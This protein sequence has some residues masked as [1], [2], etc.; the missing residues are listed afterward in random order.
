MS[1]EIISV[2]LF[3]V[4]LSFVLYR[5]R[6]NIEFKTGLIIRR[7]SRGKA[8]IYK[9]AEKHEKKLRILGLIGILV[10]FLASL[11][12]TYLL[13]K[14]TYDVFTRKTTESPLRVVLPS[15]EG[16][17]MPGFVLG[18]PFWYW[19]ISVFVVMLIHEPMH[20][21]MARIE[22][23]DIKSFGLL[24]FL[25]IPG[26]FVEPNERQLKRKSLIG[27][28]RVF[29]AGS[30]GNIVAAGIIF[31]LILGFTKVTS[32]FI[33]PVGVGF[34]SLITGSYAESVELRG[35]ITELNGVKIK[36]LND[37]ALAMKDV[38]PGD[39]VVV[40]TDKG[41]YIIKTISDPDNGQR[42]LVGIQKV[43]VQYRYAPFISNRYVSKNLLSV[44]DWI[45]GL[46][47]WM[48]I[49]NL[50]VGV[51][52]LFPLKPLD[53]GLML[54]AISQHFFKRNGSKISNYISLI[55]LGLILFNLFGP[56][57]LSLFKI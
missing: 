45:D 5:D 52:N 27:K 9:F 53:G 28:L 38:K 39:D 25:V 48:L 36:D 10:A 51:F 20:A 24:I 13:L 12:G 40:K 8:F 30:F 44:I 50:G 21:F 16:V 34:E 55:I 4:F 11:Y 6:K 26:A 54:E 23:I 18:V 37:F 19:I 46:F 43:Y 15:V 35:I 49:L 2:I 47:A 14:S 1:F 56:K 32:I 22:K 3:L 7:S 41:K 31:L 57:I 42:A 29:A 33:Q 17:S